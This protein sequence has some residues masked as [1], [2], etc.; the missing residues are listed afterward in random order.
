MDNE[1]RLTLSQFVERMQTARNGNS[2]PSGT[3]ATTAAPPR[4]QL[5]TDRNA[6]EFVQPPKRRGRP[7]KV[8]T[9]GNVVAFRR[10]PQ[11]APSND[12]AIAWMR[13]LTAAV[14]EQ[15]KASRLARAQRT[16][17]RSNSEG[18]RND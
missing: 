3:C 18:A 1:T 7:R 8:Q 17:A 14:Q 11:Q 13:E 16:G 5:V 2:S 15:R 6:C 4:L 9:G 10:L 12:R